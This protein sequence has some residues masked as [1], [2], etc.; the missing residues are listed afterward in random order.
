MFL[1]EGILF[2]SALFNICVRAGACPVL[3]YPSTLRPLFQLLLKSVG[4]AIISLSLL[5]VSLGGMRF[6]NFFSL[7]E[8]IPSPFFF[9]C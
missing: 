8:N 9:F 2:S 6:S 5:A 3:L 4:R 1:I 7:S